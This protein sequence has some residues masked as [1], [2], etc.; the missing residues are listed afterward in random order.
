MSLRRIG[1]HPLWR[2]NLFDGKDG[3]PAFFGV[4]FLYADDE[5]VRAIG[6]LDDITGALHDAVNRVSRRI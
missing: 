2:L 1:Y 4:A 6:A 3:Q 5:P